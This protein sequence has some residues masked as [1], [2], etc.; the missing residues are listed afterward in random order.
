MIGIL[1]VLFLCCVLRIYG[2]TNYYKIIGISG[3][4]RCQR[5]GTIYSTP[6]EY[7]LKTVILMIVVVVLVPIF[8]VIMIS[9]QQRKAKHAQYMMDKRHE[10]SMKK[11]GRI[12]KRGHQSTLTED[13]EEYLHQR[14]LDDIKQ[15]IHH[16]LI[17]LCEMVYFVFSAPY[18]ASLQQA[19][20][21]KIKSPYQMG[22]S[23]S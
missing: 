1:H 4:T 10:Q 22:T 5:A 13:E 15:Q 20:D 16:P 18:L 7:I 11:I 17:W 3:N 14:L 12:R 2:G 19:V 9:A 21:I 23:I 6:E 8:V